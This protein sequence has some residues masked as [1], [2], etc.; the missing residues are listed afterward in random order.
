MMWHMVWYVVCDGTVVGV[1]MM[2][3]CRLT[4]VQYFSCVN[5][6]RICR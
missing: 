2:V 1:V 4:Q 3:Y 5:S 6:C